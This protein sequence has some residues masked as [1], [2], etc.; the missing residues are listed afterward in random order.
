ME[1]ISATAF[2]SPI[3][4]KI[5]AMRTVTNEALNG[6]LSFALPLASHLFILFE[7]KELSTDS[8]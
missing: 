2:T 1:I 6:S 3:A 4:T 7:G 8:A 5:K